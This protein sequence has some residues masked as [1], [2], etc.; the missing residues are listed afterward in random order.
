MGAE[1][2]AQIVE[3]VSGGRI[4]EVPVAAAMVLARA[5][6]DNVVGVRA[7]WVVEKYFGRHV[8]KPIQ[9]RHRRQV[10]NRIAVMGY[11]PPDVPWHPGCVV[12]AR[13]GDV[14]GPWGA[15]GDGFPHGKLPLP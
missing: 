10:D 2:A 14:P 12:I 9:R 15:E 11:T 5:V 6:A 7:V 8:F 13:K 4:H 1:S 3:M